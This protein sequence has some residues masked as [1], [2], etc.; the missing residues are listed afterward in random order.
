LKE[1][2]IGGDRRRKDVVER[3]T[4]DP[5]LEQFPLLLSWRSWK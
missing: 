1:I 4:L 3:V 5:L 2:V